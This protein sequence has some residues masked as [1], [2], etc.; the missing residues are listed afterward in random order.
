LAGHTV[1]MTVFSEAWQGW[2]ARFSK[3]SGWPVDALLAEVLAQHARRLEFSE[4]APEER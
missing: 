3:H 2:L 1:L 4:P